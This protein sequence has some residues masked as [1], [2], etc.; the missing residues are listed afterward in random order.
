MTKQ[1][2][3]SGK[4]KDKGE[5]AKAIREETEGQTAP[6][7]P[8]PTGEQDLAADSIQHDRGVKEAQERQV[9]GDPSLAEAPEAEGGGGQPE[10]Q[11]GPTSTM[12]PDGANPE[13]RGG[14][15]GPDGPDG[16]PRVK[17]SALS[18]LREYLEGV[19]RKA[20]EIH[21][22]IDDRDLQGRVRQAHGA[23]ENLLDAIREVMGKRGVSSPIPPK[24]GG[25]GQPEGGVNPEGPVEG[26]QPPD[27]QVG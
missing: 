3:G 21:D 7:T 26:V 8:L 5:Q 18:N 6:A 19:V 2:K 12:G 22:R 15:S 10:P 25:E 20:E 24:D 27:Q 13:P 4:P 11:R 16:A 23:A 14:G 9:E 1:D 17:L